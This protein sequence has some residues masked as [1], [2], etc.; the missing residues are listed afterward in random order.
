MT[1]GPSTQIGL[2]LNPDLVGVIGVPWKAIHSKAEQIRHGK[3]LL[4]RR[5]VSDFKQVLK[6]IAFRYL[7]LEF[8]SQHYFL[9]FV[10]VSG[11]HSTN[12]TFFCPV[13][14]PQRKPINGV[15]KH[16]CY[17]RYCN[18]EKSYLPTFMHWFSYNVVSIYRPSQGSS[19]ID[20]YSVL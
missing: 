8:H 5:H 2:R 20:F 11:L 7:N 14:L 12:E 18:Q 17:C 19:R 10:I 6:E 13:S 4:E 16:I 1:G 15:H 3:M 9:L